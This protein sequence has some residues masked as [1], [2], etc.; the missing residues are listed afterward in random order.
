MA[1]VT[2]NGIHGGIP[3]ASSGLSNVMYPA[4][5]ANPMVTTQRSH[6]YQGPQQWQYQYR[7]MNAGVVY[8]VPDPT[9]IP[10]V[11]R[12]PSLKGKE[13]ERGFT[14]GSSRAPSFLENRGELY[15]STYLEELVTPTLTLQDGV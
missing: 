2:A 3:R 6:S 11:P 9:H 14:P 13:V 7:K 8:S 5:H 12:F 10:A 4:A 15:P 1:N